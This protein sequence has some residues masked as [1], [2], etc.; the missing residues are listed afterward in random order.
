[1]KIFV[2]GPNIFS[3]YSTVK[4]VLI[5]LTAILGGYIVSAIIA[6]PP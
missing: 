6:E 4:R 1:M 5:W 2:S 3:K